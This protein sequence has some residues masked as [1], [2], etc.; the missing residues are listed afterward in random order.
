MVREFE[1]FQNKIIP[2]RIPKLK[3]NVTAVCKKCN[4]F[5]QKK[6]SMTTICDSCWEKIMANRANKLSSLHVCG[7]CGEL[8]QIGEP[9][10]LV[11]RAIKL[12][13][14]DSNRLLDRY[15][16]KTEGFY[17]AECWDKKLKVFLKSEETVNKLQG[18]INSAFHRKKIPQ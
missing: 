3:K 14:N 18:L 16:R 17:H 11:S 13:R 10:I 8:I 1:K 4:N 9:R 12:S 6:T 7:L 2:V 5:F 15:E